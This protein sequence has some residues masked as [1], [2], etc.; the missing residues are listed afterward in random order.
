MTPKQQ[1]EIQRSELGQR[2]NGLLARAQKGEELSE[3]EMKE[4]EEAD[5]KTEELEKRYRAAIA[6]ESL[7]AQQWAEKDAGSDTSGAVDPGTHKELSQIANDARLAPFVQRAFQGVELDRSSPEAELSAALGLTQGNMT[8]VPWPL[9]LPPG[10]IPVPQHPHAAH[11]REMPPMQE[12]R[13]DAVTSLEAKQPTL[14]MGRWLERLFAPTV[15]AWFGVTVESAQ[16]GDKSHVVQTAGTDA[17]VRARGAEGDAKAYTFDVPE[18]S[19]HRVTAQ[20]IWQIEDIARIPMLESFLRMDL[21]RVMIDKLEQ[22]IWDGGTG[23]Y[24]ATGLAPA[25]V[26]GGNKNSI[27]YAEAT[28]TAS[29]LREELAKGIDGIYAEDTMDLR[30]LLAIEAYKFMLNKADA[31]LDELTLDTVKKQGYMCRSSRRVK[32][33]AIDASGDVWAVMSKANGL[34]GAATMAVWPTLGLIHDQ[35][36]RAD[37]GETVLTAHALAD[38]G[39]IRTDNFYV[40]NKT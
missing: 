4:I 24:S 39:A 3:E 35:Y 10:E 26:T 2:L 31:D 37:H 11:R 7:L 27:V 23:F 18:L 20:Y 32:A 21:A 6:A 30:V 9:L 25:I 17:N 40:L 29:D 36:S 1:L 22:V 28:T 19:P 13:A 14:V 16:V 12:I 38:F 5:K 33:D 34:P 8:E 15:A